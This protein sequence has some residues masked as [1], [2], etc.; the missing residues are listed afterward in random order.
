MN[1]T[2]P[3]THAARKVYVC[4]SCGQLIPVGGSY[5]RWRCYDGGDAGTVKMHTEC[6]DMHDAEA[7]GTWEF[8]PFSYERPN[9]VRP[10]SE[11][12]TP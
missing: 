10:S 3:T 9:A 8:T 4:Q 2:Q 1:C 11:L 6:F 7:E 12:V 5:T